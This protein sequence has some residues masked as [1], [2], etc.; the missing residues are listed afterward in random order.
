MKVR[1]DVFR[2]K[3]GAADSYRQIFE[4]DIQPGEDVLNAFHKIQEE[5]DPTFAFRYSC[6]GA[7]CGS[8]AVRINGTAMLA[9]KT[10]VLP[11]AETGTIVVDPMANMPVIRDLVTDLDDGFWPAY[12]SVRPYL[13]RAEDKH[14]ERLTW[15]DKLTPRNLDQLVRS[16]DCIKCAACYSD[17]PKVAEDKA[18]FIGPQACIQLYKFYWDPRDADH[19]W[20][21]GPEAGASPIGPLACDNHG[22]CVRVC[23][24]DCR[25]LVGITL[26]RRDVKPK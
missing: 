20:R 10:Q 12:D 15:D 9:C 11:L 19:A 3:P 22:N 25:P 21:M 6:R 8:C 1:F 18:G 7:I 17:C 5:H 4:L 13:V 23:P 14:D 24:K 26:I 16:E 2:K